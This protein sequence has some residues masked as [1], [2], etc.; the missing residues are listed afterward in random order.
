[1]YMRRCH[2]YILV[3]KSHNNAVI[4]NDFFLLVYVII[5]FVLC[6]LY[7]YYYGILGGRRGS[8][9]APPPP[10]VCNPGITVYIKI[11]AGQKS[12]NSFYQCCNGRH[13]IILYAIFYRIKNCMIKFSSGSE[14]GENFLLVKIFMYT[15]I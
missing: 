4:T 7:V 1:M 11:F 3:N 10:P 14:I 5:L 13:N 2:A 8:Q 9:C 15:V 12:E 6:I